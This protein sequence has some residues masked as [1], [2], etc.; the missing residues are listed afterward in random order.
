MKRIH[1]LDL[2]RGIAI[3]MVVV[4]HRL[5]FDWTGAA[6]WFEASNPLLEYFWFSIIMFFV[7]MGGIFSLISGTVTSYS[8]HDRLTTGRNTIK[9]IMLGS[10]ISFF[11]LEFLHFL[12]G[13]PWIFP[14]S[15]SVHL[16]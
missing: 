10:L 3:M 4:L 7:G 15:P 12:Y 5:V 11:W 14:K 1:S 9:Q 8:T 2:F 13:I 6:A 16:N